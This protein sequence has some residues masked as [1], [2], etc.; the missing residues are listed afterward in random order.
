MSSESLNLSSQGLTT[1]TLTSSFSDT[2][3]S[4][5]VSNNPINN[6]CFNVISSLS[7][8][9]HLNLSNTHITT[10]VQLV[11]LSHLESLNVSHCPIDD[12]SLESCISTIH[13]LSNLH[14]LDVTGTI[15]A[16]HSH[17]LPPV[18][19]V[20]ESCLNDDTV[21]V[22][23]TD[24]TITDTHNHLKTLLSSKPNPHSNRAQP[25]SLSEPLIPRLSSSDNDL[26]DGYR[27]KLFN[28]LIEKHEMVETF[29]RK[30]EV[31][32]EELDSNTS[33]LSESSKRVHYLE[34][35]LSA[36]NDTLQKFQKDNLRLLNEV[37][38][39]KGVINS[40]QDT[41]KKSTDNQKTFVST[42]FHDISKF[43]NFFNSALDRLLKGCDQVTTHAQSCQD[44]ADITKH[45]SSVFSDLLSSQ[46]ALHSDYETLLSCSSLEKKSYEERIDRLESTVSELNQNYL[47]VDREN[48]ELK[49]QLASSFS[50]K[51]DYFNEYERSVDLLQ[52]KETD[53]LIVTSKMNKLKKNVML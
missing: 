33:R 41:L 3:C 14:S 49:A 48:S 10:L 36:N 27:R 19:V 50:Q 18:N 23:S 9:K 42:I 32:S 28:L 44:I 22:T 29:S 45:V 51:D 6:E 20:T 8:L 11:S 21:S 46:Q 26:L 47:T 16:R 43:S 35:E 13:K 52:K 7:Y 53:Y 39:L 2:I 37:S 30:I 25:L 17:L 34:E 31:L 1:L 38:V 5:D 24:T 12:V 15:L 40:L 4:L